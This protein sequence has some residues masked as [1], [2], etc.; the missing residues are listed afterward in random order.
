M[1]YN[2]FLNKQMQ[3]PEAE[4]LQHTGASSRW[5]TNKSLYEATLEG[6]RHIIR[7]KTN[8]TWEN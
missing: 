8:S 7:N 3:H 1:K 5:Q 4:V 2:Q 6:L